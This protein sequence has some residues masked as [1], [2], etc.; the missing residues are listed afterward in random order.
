MSPLNNTAATL[1]VLVPVGPVGGKRHPLHAA[2]ATSFVVLVTY[3][4][5]AGFESSTGSDH[6]K[7]K[8]TC[9]TRL[10]RRL[11]KSGRGHN[12]ACLLQA[13]ARHSISLRRLES[14]DLEESGRV[15]KSLCGAHPAQSKATPFSE[16]GRVGRLT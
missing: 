6:G 8:P 15:P 9:I 16:Q 7:P 11:P 10:P 5:A 1:V 4:S 13:P 2:L 14:N 3:A 12:R